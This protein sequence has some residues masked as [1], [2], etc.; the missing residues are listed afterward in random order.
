MSVATKSVE[1]F[2]FSG[3]KGSSVEA[4]QLVELSPLKIN[5]FSF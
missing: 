5:I 2:T 4:F 3:R 1:A